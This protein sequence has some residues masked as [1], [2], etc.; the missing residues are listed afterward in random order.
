MYNIVYTQISEY[1][2]FKIK[3]KT[4][5]FSMDPKP[6]IVIPSVVREAAKKV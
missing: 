4:M 3:T 2:F 1:I 6:Q 5:L